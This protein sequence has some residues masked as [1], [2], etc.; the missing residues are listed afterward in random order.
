LEAVHSGAAGFLAS[1]ASISANLAM[2]MHFRVTS[3][4]FA[5]DA[6]RFCAGRKQCPQ[7]VHARSCLSG[8]N[9][10]CCGAYVR[11][12][13]VLADALNEIFDHFLAK[14]GIGATRAGLG[15]GVALFD[16]AEQFTTRLT[17]SFRMGDH[18]VAGIHRVPPGN[19]KGRGRLT[20]GAARWFLVLGPCDIAVVFIGRCVT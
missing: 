3:A 19:R 20:F 6:A 1:A 15:T 17:C 12:V 7:D 10:T 4:L 2:L 8:R 9:G 5:A 18:H 14:T 11:A 13:Q 16:A